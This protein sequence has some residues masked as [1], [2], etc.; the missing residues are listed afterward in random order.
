MRGGAGVTK[1]RPEPFG[2]AVA[3]AALALAAAAGCVLPWEH[4]DVATPGGA[5]TTPLDG[6]HG[7]GILGCV[8]AAIALLAVA[9]RAWRPVASLWR[10]VAVA[11][12]GAALVAGAALFRSWGG[13]PVG[14]SVGGQSTVS[15]GPGLPIAGSAGLALLALSLALVW[16]RRG[17]SRSPA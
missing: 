15:L 9:E 11:A 1:A 2:V 7:W 14:S 17:G 13:Y 10:D 3:R 5:S 12:A 8:G 4:L 6:L 16:L